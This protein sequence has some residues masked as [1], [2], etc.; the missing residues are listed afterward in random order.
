M[1]DRPRYI[2]GDSV[3][4]RCD[5]IVGSYPREEFTGEELRFVEPMT[6]YIGKTVTIQNVCTW[7]YR[8][9]EDGN[10]FWWCDAFFEDSNKYIDT[11]DLLKLLMEE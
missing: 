4:V 11:N 1:G 6:Y 5:L 7:G 2:E 3:K 9:V 10:A 8:I